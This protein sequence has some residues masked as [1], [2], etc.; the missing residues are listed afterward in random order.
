MGLI[1]VHPHTMQIDTPKSYDLSIGIL[2]A[3]VGIAV[4][5]PKLQIKILVIKLLA[6]LLAQC[7][8]P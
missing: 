8:R 6:K 2:A 3:G 5:W 7:E 4:W 1:H